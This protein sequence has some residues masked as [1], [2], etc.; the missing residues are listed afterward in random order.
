MD[1]LTSHELHISLIIEAA[2]LLLIAISIIGYL[3]LRLIRLSRQMAASADSGPSVTEYLRSEIKKTHEKQAG[4]GNNGAEARELHAACDLRCHVFEGEIRLLENADADQAHYWQPIHDYY[5]AIQTEFT[6]QITKLKEHLQV[7]QERI[8]NLEKFKEKVFDLRERL[9]A[10]HQ[11]SKRL[12]DELREKIKDGAKLTELEHTL[13]QMEREKGDLVKELQLAENEFLAIMENAGAGKTGAID[14]D[15][16]MPEIA[17][18]NTREKELNAQLAMVKDENEFL[19]DQIQALLTLEIKLEGNE[20]E[21]DKQIL[22]LEK[23]YARM[24]E[25]YLA[26]QE[27]LDNSV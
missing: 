24:E 16:G 1:F 17:V 13:S 9:T 3:L 12:E 10:A 18:A 23:R 5:Q 25:R 22:A 26:L 20:E 7:A 6:K 2:I 19:C 15:N 14:P 4:L 8:G 11:N 21:K 27:E